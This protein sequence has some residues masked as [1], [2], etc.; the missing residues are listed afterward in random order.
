[1]SP[2]FAL[3]FHHVFSSGIFPDSLKNTKV[4]PIFKEGSKTDANNYLS[5]SILPCLSKLVEKLIVK[6]V[7]SFLDKHEGTQP[8]QFGFR[9]KYS[10][11]HVLLDTLSSCYDA[12]NEKKNLSLIMIDLQKA[13]DTVCHKK[14]INKVRT[15][16]NSRYRQ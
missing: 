11:I 7:T 1:M 15:L 16:W 14:T 5:I 6:R 2:F 4:V 3:F 8:H 12:I 10:T 9:E 13:F